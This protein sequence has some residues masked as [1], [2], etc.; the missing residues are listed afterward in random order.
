VEAGA[1]ELVVEG[2]KWKIV[3]NVLGGEERGISA[4]DPQGF[5]GRPLAPLLYAK[6]LAPGCR[7][8]VHSVLW[9]AVTGNREIRGG[10]WGAGAPAENRS[11]GWRKA[12]NGVKERL[13]LRVEVVTVQMETFLLERLHDLQ[14][15]ESSIATDD[16]G[17]FV[18]NTLNSPRCCPNVLERVICQSG[19]RRRLAVG[20]LILKRENF[21]EC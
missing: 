10:E 3:G 20:P 16:V 15:R 9:E 8:S 7:P 19:R 13:L 14:V 5:W 4:D 2:R 12:I 17:S 11:R 21:F 18:Q 6:S 1:R